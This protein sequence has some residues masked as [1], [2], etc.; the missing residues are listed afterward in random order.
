MKAISVM[1]IVMCLAAYQT[2]AN[3]GL[4][5]TVADLEDQNGN[6]IPTN[7]LAIMVADTTGLGMGGGVSNLAANSSLALG[8]NLT[9]QGGGA[10]DLIVGRWNSFSG[11][12]QQGLLS[13]VAFVSLHP[14][15]ATGENLYLLW[16]PTLTL[17]DTA[18]G[19]GVQYGGYG[20]AAATA[21]LDGGNAWQLPSDG[22]ALELN[23]ITPNE[24][25]ATPQANL[26]AS[27]VTP[28]MLI[29]EPSSIVLVAIGL[30]GALG[31]SRL[32]GGPK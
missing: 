9:I 29:P 18:I 25:G 10:G 23:A 3:V 4:F 6:L 16:F 24:G 28:I 26:A 27:F 32:Q 2:K 8:T 22:G 31:L 21:I 1:L 30:F 7:T 17:S 19:A 5:V 20:G 11:S 13:D 12:D 14:P 15:L